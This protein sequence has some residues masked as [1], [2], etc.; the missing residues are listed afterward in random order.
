MREVDVLIVGAGPAGSA[1]ALNLAPFCR[2]MLVDKQLTPGVR[3]GESLIPAARRLLQDMGLLNAFLAQNHAPH[4]GNRAWWNG[5]V[6]Q[7][8]DFLR[9]AD[10]PGW[11]LDR[12]SFD[13]F[14]RECAER[15][16]AILHCPVKLDQVQ[17]AAENECWQVRLRYPNGVRELSCRLILDASGRAAVAARRLGSVRVAR[18]RLVCGWLQ[19]VAEIE[20]PASAGFST[21]EAE[22]AGWWYSAPLP[23]R[24]RVLAFHT[25][26]D[27]PEAAAARSPEWLLS[28][29]RL[30]PG[31]TALLR[32]TGFAPTAVSGYTAAHSAALRP[33]AGEGW[34]ALGDAAFC[35]D[36]LSS[37]GLFNALYTGLAAAECGHRFLRGQTDAFTGYRMELARIGGMY[38]RHL[39]YWYATEAR[40]A[41]APFWQRRRR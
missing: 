41:N 8:T 10:G 4:F 19:G 14:L 16:G 2:V 30:R 37:R 35:F 17:R 28:R 9:D 36:P 6:P 25:D 12:A 21:V 32:E 3:I 40:W 34:A 33:A 18:D 1:A 11:H 29:A 26:A 7:E 39:R 22:P 13:I 5:A 24:R 23:S 27:L 20:T 31:M 38:D 15:R